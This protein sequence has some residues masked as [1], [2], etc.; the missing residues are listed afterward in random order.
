MRRWWRER[1]RSRGRVCCC[2]RRRRCWCRSRSSSRSTSSRALPAPHHPQLK[3]R[4]QEHDQRHRERRQRRV[5]P[6]PEKGSSHPRRARASLGFL[7][8]FRL[9]VEPRRE[10]PVGPPRGKLY[11]GGARGVAEGEGTDCVEMGSSR[12]RAGRGRRRK[13]DCDSLSAAFA[14]LYSAPPARRAAPPPPLLRVREQQC[15]L[16][17]ALEGCLLKVIREKW[18]SRKREKKRVSFRDFFERASE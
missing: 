9:S 16:A 14:P 17:A 10:Q 13:C 18:Q 4:Q 12:S 8:L 6:Q 3:H 11:R 7:P 15:H 2:R 5:V 1:K